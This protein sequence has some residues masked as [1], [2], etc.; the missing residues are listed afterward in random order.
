MGRGSL[1][2]PVVAGAVCFPCEPDRKLKK[3]LT[4]LDDSKK[5]SADV[6]AD[7][8]EAIH[9]H[10]WVGIGAADKDEVD[11]LNIH[12]AS[13]LALH[14]AFE[15]LCDNAGLDRRTSDAFLLIDG[16][17]L[18]P[19]YRRERQKAV[20]KGDGTSAAIAAASVVAKH[21][22]DSLCQEWA[23]QYP[24]YEWESNMGYATPAHQRAMSELGLTPLHRKNFKKVMEQMSLA[25]EFG[26]AGTESGHPALSL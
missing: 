24:G 14:R 4:W 12:Y 16:R 23:R 17:A 5:L 22:R 2:G 11:R 19:D 21:Y 3:L 8:S 20:V 10:C 7:L 1:I 9:A 18:I 25:L 6:R 15:A 13:L 26:G